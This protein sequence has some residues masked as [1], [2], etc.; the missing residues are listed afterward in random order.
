MVDLILHKEYTVH[1]YETD[2][3]GL[4]RLRTRWG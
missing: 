4:A 3:R 2:A 1:T